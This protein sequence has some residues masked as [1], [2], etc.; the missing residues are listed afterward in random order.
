MTPDQYAKF[1]QT[2]RKMGLF[3]SG[4]SSGFLRLLNDRQMD[5][6]DAAWIFA[7]A[8]PIAKL[9]RWLILI[10]LVFLVARLCGVI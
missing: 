1:N 3:R 10:G 6:A 5:P 8:E 9:V 2:L 4:K 7:I